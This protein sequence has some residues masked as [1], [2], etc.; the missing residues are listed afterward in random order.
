MVRGNIELEKLLEDISIEA[1]Q[2]KEKIASSTCGDGEGEPD[3][4]EVAAFGRNLAKEIE[5]GYTC[6]L[7]PAIQ[8]SKGVDIF[9]IFQ[10]NISPDKSSCQPP[11]AKASGLAP[12]SAP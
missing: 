2:M 7:K 10:G 3:L 12:N 9:S 4:S 11:T 1:R 5:S 6:P 8:S